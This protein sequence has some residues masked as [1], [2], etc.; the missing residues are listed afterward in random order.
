MTEIFDG[1]RMPE[2]KRA[3]VD[4][5][6]AWWQTQMVSTPDRLAALCAAR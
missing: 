4:S 5:G 1:S 2:D 6:R 3:E